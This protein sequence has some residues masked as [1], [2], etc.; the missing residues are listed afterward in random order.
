MLVG[1]TEF[2]ER[3]RL[4]RGERKQ[5]PWSFRT[6]HE[7]VAAWMLTG[8]AIWSSKE[9]KPKMPRIPDRQ[10]FMCIDISVYA[11][12]KWMYEGFFFVAVASVL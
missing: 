12:R 7:L 9:L 10:V 4:A 8:L 3:A 1:Q 2:S 6:H 11:C 5:P